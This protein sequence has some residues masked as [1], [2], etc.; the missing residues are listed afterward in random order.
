V[1]EDK[2]GTEMAVQLALQDVLELEV[3][4]LSC[5]NARFVE[6]LAEEYGT[7]TGVCIFVRCFV[8]LL[9]I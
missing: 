2:C 9:K 5:L 3:S 4:P 6:W 8:Y 1:R 7:S